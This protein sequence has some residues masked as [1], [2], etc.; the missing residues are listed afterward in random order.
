M[1]QPF[2]RVR[3]ARWGLTEVPADPRGIPGGHLYESFK[4]VRDLRTKESLRVTYDTVYAG[5][6]LHLASLQEEYVAMK[7]E[8]N[9][10]V[11]DLRS[12]YP[13]YDREAIRRDLVAGKKIAKT[14]IFTIDL[15]VT[16]EPTLPFGQLRYGGKSVKSPDIRE[17][18]EVLRRSERE[19]AFCTSWDWSWE[20]A[21]VPAETEIAS[22]SNLRQ[23]AR[24]RPL[25]EGAKD[26]RELAHQLYK[27]SSNK[28]LFDL[29]GMLGRRIGVSHR[30]QFFVFGAA[31]YLGMI[32]LDLN[33]PVDEEYPPCLLQMPHR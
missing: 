25:D 5:T 29:L 11:V 4:Q 13:C 21:E 3:L 17:Q 7:V 20:Y 14:R 30:D 10:A 8:A 32:R 33:S 12:A 24:A 6:R 27:T 16:Y 26:A 22:L 2:S 9:S 31:Y 1:A 15:M 28:P 18:P 23:W 19:R